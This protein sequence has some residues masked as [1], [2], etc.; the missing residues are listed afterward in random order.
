MGPFNGTPRILS[1]P[2]EIWFAGLRSTTSVMQQAGW[3]FAVHED[4][5]RREIALAMRHRDFGLYGWAAILDYDHF[6]FEDPR[7]YPRREL[8]FQVVNMVEDRE[9]RRVTTIPDFSKFT[10]ADMAPQ[11]CISEYKCIEDFK[12]FATPLVRTEEIIVEPETV[13]SLLEKI[14]QMQSPDQ[15][16]IRERMRKRDRSEM[17]QRQRFHA[18]IL[19]LEAA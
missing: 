12:I 7:C 11:F 3:E 13:M 1:R 8:N 18:Q 14:K 10:P 4:F 19:S 2:C 16:A 9:A 15:S 17:T 5:G 6:A